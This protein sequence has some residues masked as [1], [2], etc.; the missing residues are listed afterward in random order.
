MSSIDADSGGPCEAFASEDVDSVRS[1]LSHL[2]AD[3]TYIADSDDASN[4]GV[5]Y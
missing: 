4:G 3:D 1:C 2:E 5:R